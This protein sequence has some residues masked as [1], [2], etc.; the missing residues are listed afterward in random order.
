MTKAISLI[1]PCYN[2]EEYI[3]RFLD[4]LLAQTYPDIKLIFVNDGST[5][6]TKEILDSYQPLFKKRGYQILYLSQPN[7]GQAAAIN[8]GLQKL[9]T[10][11]VMW[12]DADDILM[13]DAVAEKINFLERHP[14]C[15][16]A[17]CQGLIVN[18]KDP[19]TTCSTQQ[20]VEPSTSDDPFFSDLIYERNCVFTPAAY[21]AR[22]D[23]LHKAIPTMHIYEY[24]EGQNWQLLLPISFISK[25]GYIQ[26]PLYKYVVRENS[27]S[28]MPRTYDDLISRQEG[29]F[30]A[31]EQ[32]ITSIPQMDD[33][34]K[35]AWIKMARLKCMRTKC[36]YALRNFQPVDFLIY[37][38]KT[39][40]LE[41]SRPPEQQLPNHAC[42]IY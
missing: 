1:V 21:I 22:T 27:H 41:I 3:S 14:D 6:G 29:L 25:C 34:D 7:K 2:G 33:K 40:V 38:I 9:T 28:H 10:P 8:L 31:L 36:N 39:F 26:K 13:P 23:I 20:R 4:S 17:V 30:T 12:M 16:F 18:D 19:T 5:D 24:R 11:Y 32:T 35:S 15:G 42:D 37:G